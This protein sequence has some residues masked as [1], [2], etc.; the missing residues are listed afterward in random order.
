MGYVLLVGI[1]MLLVFVDFQF[2][3]QHR[4]AYG[5]LFALFI[6]YRKIVL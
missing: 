1:L 2:R 6:W 4:V 3:F 5:F